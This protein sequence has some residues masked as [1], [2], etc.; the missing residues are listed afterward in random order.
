MELLK[1][2][3]F[4]DG[5]MRIKRNGGEHEISFFNTETLKT[6]KQVLGKGVEFII[7]Q[8]GAIAADNGKNIY[9]ISL[10]NGVVSRKAIRNAT[11]NW[12]VLFKTDPILFSSKE[13]QEKPVKNSFGIR[14]FNA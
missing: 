8:N 7:H 9:F 3:T 2:L 6:H 10:N 5:I 11:L 4:S 1:T 14:P 13:L 12:E